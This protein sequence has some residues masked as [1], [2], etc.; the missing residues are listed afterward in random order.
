MWLDSMARVKQ[1]EVRTT[2]GLFSSMLPEQREDA[3]KLEALRLNGEASLPLHVSGGC[4]GRRLPRLHWLT[5]LL[6]NAMHLATVT[7]ACSSQQETSQHQCSHGQ[8]NAV[9]VL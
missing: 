4:L 5:K 7:R 3:E 6:Q 1:H 2:C 9:M 8:W